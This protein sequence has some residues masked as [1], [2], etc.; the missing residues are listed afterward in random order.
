M[1]S[2]I[3]ILALLAGFP[4]SAAGESLQCGETLITE[5]ATESEVVARCGPP[6]QIDHQTM[7]RTAAT[8]PVGVLPPVVVRSDTEISVE[9]CT[10]NFGPQRLMQRIR[11]ENGVIV[12]MESL[13]YG[14]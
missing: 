7:Y 2:S 11:F 4:L 6:T 3:R 12:K 8:A 5:G 9:I 14:F 13:G 1:K 10:Y